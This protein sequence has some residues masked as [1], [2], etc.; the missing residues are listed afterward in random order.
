MTRPG[1]DADDKARTES[2]HFM[3]CPGCGQWFDMRDLGEV[4]KHVHDGEF[5]VGEATPDPKYKCPG[6]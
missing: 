5:E 3:K 1:R 6:S 2:D 4:A